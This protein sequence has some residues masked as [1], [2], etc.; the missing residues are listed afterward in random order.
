MTDNRKASE[1]F[2]DFDETRRKKSH[3]ETI[4]EV[5]NKWMVEHPGV[6]L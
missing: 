1:E 6:I 3:C 2:I 5:N 4:I